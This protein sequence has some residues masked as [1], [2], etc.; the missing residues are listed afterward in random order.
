[1]RKIISKVD[2]KLRYAVNG[3]SHINPPTPLKLAEYYGVAN[4]VFKYDTIPD[5]PPA[6]G[7]P[8]VTSAPIVLN[9]TFRNFVEIIFENHEK[10]IQSWHLDGYSSFAVA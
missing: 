4:K 3:I 8:K 5:D 6:R 1:M 10:S 7:V 9:M 2:G